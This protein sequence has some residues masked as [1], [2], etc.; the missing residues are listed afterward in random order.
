MLKLKGV[1]KMVTLADDFMMY[2][3]QAAEAKKCHI[4]IYR[5]MPYSSTRF[6]VNQLDEKLL[7]RIVGH[8]LPSQIFEIIFNL[9]FTETL[10]TNI[11]IDCD[12]PVPGIEGS[13]MS[14][15]L[16]IIEHYCDLSIKG[17]TK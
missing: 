7:I 4:D 1:I 17:G 13:G 5:I 6:N 3:Q 9:E 14:H 12:H 15:L 8:E 16:K 2:A 11:V 10:S